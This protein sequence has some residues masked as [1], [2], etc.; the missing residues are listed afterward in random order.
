MTGRGQ[1]PSR[2]LPFSVLLDVPHQEEHCYITFKI[3]CSSA[4][5]FKRWEPLIG[6]LTLWRQPCADSQNANLCLIYHSC[7]SLPINWN[8][9]PNKY[10]INNLYFYRKMK[11]SFIQKTNI[12]WTCGIESPFILVFNS[13]LKEVA[14]QECWNL[15]GQFVSLS[16]TQCGI[17]MPKPIWRLKYSLSKQALTIN[18]FKL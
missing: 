15:F 3:L 7:T 16:T 8:E 14:E 1:I 17:Y 18:N 12:F 11:V 2:F 5:T 9:L 10:L 6:H 13:Q 4:K